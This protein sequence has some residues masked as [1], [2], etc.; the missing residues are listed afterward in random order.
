MKST[1]ALDYVGEVKRTT[2][3]DLHR[4]LNLIKNDIRIIT[5]MKIS[6]EAK[7]PILAE[8]DRQIDD[9]KERMHNYIDTL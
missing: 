1:G 4:E 6:E 2:I 7:A 8:L 9:V 3:G 5:N